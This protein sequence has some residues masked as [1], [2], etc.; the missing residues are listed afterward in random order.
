MAK[1]KDKYRDEH[2]QKHQEVVTPPELVE[3]IYSFLDPEKDFKGKDI[4]DPCVGPGALVEPLLK[5]AHDW[6]WRSLT[7]MDI[8]ELHINEFKENL[9]KY[10]KK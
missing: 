1:V 4:L 7:V 8:Q 10:R 3:H 9:S 5:N 2:A 6:K